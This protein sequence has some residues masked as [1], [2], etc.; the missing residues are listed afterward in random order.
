MIPFACL[1]STCP[2]GPVHHMRS[3]PRCGLPNKLAH[4]ATFSAN[5]HALPS[6]SLLDVG[7][8][9]MLMC[10]KCFFASSFVKW[11]VRASLGFMLLEI[12]WNS[13]FPERTCSWSHNCFNSKC[14]TFQHPRRAKMPLTADEPPLIFMSTFSPSSLQN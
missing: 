2:F 14:L 8:D 5:V 4:A 6:A 9:S 13:T 3:W 12:F 11:C 10:L 7:I 1:L